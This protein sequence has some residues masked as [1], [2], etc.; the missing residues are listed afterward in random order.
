MAWAMDA[1][2]RAPVYI[3]KLT[4]E[5]KG[6]RCQCICPACDAQ[7]QAVN[8]GADANAPRIPFFRHHQGTQGPGCKH[9]VAELAALRLLVEKGLIEIPAPRR[10]SVFKGESGAL[11]QAEAV[12]SPVREEIVERR[13][14]SDTQAVLTLASGREVLLTLRGHQDV[15]AFG[16]VFA[17]IEID[18]RDAEAAWL[19]PEEILSRAELNGEWLHVVRHAE[20]DALQLEADDQARHEAME[21][22]DVDP[23][24]LDLPIGATK[25]QAAE[26]LVHWAL[27]EALMHIG[28]L[29]APELRTSVSAV[30]RR[31]QVHTVPVVLP[32][33]R[34]ELSDI[35]HEVL[36][37]GYRADIACL[38]TGT[39]PGA[40]S[41]HPFKL[42]IEVAVTSRV[43]I[44]K[45]R[46]IERADVACIELDVFG[47]AHGGLAS[48]PQLRELVKTDLSC[49]TWLHHPR[50]RDLIAQAQE[51][52]DAA[53]D[54][55]DAAGD[56]HEAAARRQRRMEE[57][58]EATRQRLAEARRKWVEGLG[59]EEAFAELRRFLEQR[60]QGV[61]PVTSNGLTWQDGE[62]EKAVA[63]LMAPIT[64]GLNAI[65]PGAIAWKLRAIVHSAAT[66]TAI[67]GK[68]IL[69]LGL[70]YLPFDLE[71][72]LGLLHLAVEERGAVVSEQEAG[73]YAAQRQVVLKSLEDGQVNY[74]RS[75]NLDP[76]L[77]GLFPEL[78]PVF[79]R[80][81]GTDSY[82]ERIQRE[83]RAVAAQ[84]QEEKRIADEAAA[85]LLAEQQAAA[86]AEIERRKLP[87]AIAAVC[88]QWLWR[89]NL[90]VPASA[91]KAVEFLNYSS[92]K[93]PGR[94]LVALVR[95]AWLARTRGEDF[96]QWFASKD[97][98]A[99]D[100]VNL[101]RAV[102][103]AACLVQSKLSKR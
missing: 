86:A 17:V 4:R 95:E 34:L 92:H 21:Q 11:Y 29:L 33:T 64:W 73:A 22:L 19:S 25:K 78:R 37:D 13:L 50:A 72:W 12:G 69:G 20:H 18:V 57:E 63:K 43:T 40:P 76:L 52:A 81:L 103:E 42:I 68:A 59:R 45:L 51:K 30:G 3:G 35:R 75:T 44:E 89:D 39:G 101:A 49:K 10:Q 62:F 41:D 94:A 67:D 26:T 2:T 80:E 48:K 9:R 70:P 27:K 14:V 84:Q 93:N 16:S 60:W 36:F 1:R 7:L 28:W 38:A 23:A 54:V 55:A 5:H 77:T 91:E 79:D 15:G 82:R 24:L 99:A 66:N 47:F 97:F 61:N 96:A 74:V 83:R 102:L 6:L 8:A 100:E 53:R 90:K 87:E 32:A 71:P 31:G 56:A 58:R 85:A 65:T 88:Y 98:A 46:L